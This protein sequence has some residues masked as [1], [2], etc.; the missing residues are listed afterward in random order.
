ML[1]MFEGNQAIDDLN[2]TITEWEDQY[3]QL[4]DKYLEAKKDSDDWYRSYK[5]LWDF[6]SYWE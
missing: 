4:Y 5:A 2:E 6:Y 3:Q 1:E